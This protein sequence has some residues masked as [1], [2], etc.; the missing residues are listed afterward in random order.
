MDE[1]PKGD[2]VTI[3]K[4]LLKELLQRLENIEKILR[5]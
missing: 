2:T 3:S 4:T 1:T 5:G